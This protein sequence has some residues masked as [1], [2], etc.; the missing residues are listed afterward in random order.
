MHYTVAVQILDSD[1][2]LIGEF[3]DARLRYLEVPVLNVVEEIL[4][5][6]ILQ[7]NIVVVAVLEEVYER[8]DIRMLRLLKHFNFTSLLVNLNLLH[9][10]LVHGLDGDFL[11]RLLMRCELD[12]TELALAQ[13]VLERIVVE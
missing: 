2:N 8:D 10:L 1:A 7:H 4:A 11:A 12:E 5:L 3:F 9:I 6:H 13:V